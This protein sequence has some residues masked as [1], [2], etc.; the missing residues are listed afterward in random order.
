MNPIV[1]TGLLTA[2][3][4]RM[5]PHIVWY[6]TH[7]NRL[8]ADL[9]Q[10]QDR[11]PTVLN[12][13]KACTRERTFRNLLYYR[14]GEYR[15]FFVSW[16]LPPDRSLTIWCPSIGPGAHLEH[17]YAT[18]LNAERIGSDFYCL[19]LVTLGN[20]HGGR[21]TIG[22]RVR[23][24]T[25]ATVFGGITIGDDVTIGAGAVVCRSVPDGCTVVGN[26]ARVVRRYGERVDLPL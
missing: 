11:V 12:L 20:G 9:A 1:Q 2:S 24:M 15:A 13:V 22:H 19:Q 14:M 23:V 3:A 16:L 21:P 5:L 26:P 7:R 10:V 4:L 6:L 25:G 18:Y 17:S 8:A